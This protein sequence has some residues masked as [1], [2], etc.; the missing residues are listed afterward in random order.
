MIK[1]GTRSVILDLGC[2]LRALRAS[3]FFTFVAV[4]M[5]ALG[6]AFSGIV[7]S[8]VNSVLLRSLPYPDARQLV[9]LQTQE[10]QG[11]VIEDLTASAFFFVRDNSVSL[12]NVTAIYPFEA[13]FNLAASHRTQYVKVLRVSTD[14]F[15]ALRSTPAIGRTFTESED[16]PNGPKLAVLS[17][18]LWK[19]TLGQDRLQT[20][21]VLRINGEEYIAIGVMPPDFRSYPEADLWLPLQ[22]SP[23]TA[24]PGTDYRV[25]ARLRRGAS[26]Q[27]A[28]EELRQ[29]S[30]N[31][32]MN[33]IPKAGRVSLGLQQL[34]DYET[35]NVRER[36]M[37]LLC[38]VLF[39]LLIACANIAMLLL[40]RASA[41][42]H[43]IAVRAALGSSRIR[44]LQVLFFESSILAFFAWLFG[45]ILTKELLPV[46]VSLVPGGL[47]RIAEIHIDWRVVIFTLGISALTALLFGLAPAIQLRGSKLDKMLR[48]TPS[49][50]IGS[51]RQAGTGRL[52]L[53]IQTALT[54]V[55]LSS[56]MLL[57]RHFLAIEKIAP[58]FDPRLVSVAQVSLSSRSY[59]T[60]APTARM[61]ESIISQLQTLPSVSGVAAINGLP[62]EKALNM[63]VHPV[64]AP[65][66]VEGAEY[67]SISPEYFT[68]MRI[69]TVEG[70]SFKQ[71]DGPHSL[72]VAI[73]NETLARKWWPGKYLGHFVLAGQ[74]IGE[75]FTDQPR[76]VVGV[77]SDVHESGLDKPAPPT[78]FVPLQQVPDKLTEYANKNFLTSIVAR[79]NWSEDVSPE[80]RSA[81]T[82]ADQDLSVASFRPLDQVVANSMARERFFTVLT[83]TFGGF[84]L[85]ITAIGLY[86]LL[87]YQIGLRSREIAVRVCLGAKRSHIVVLIVQQ[88]AV[89][90]GAGVAVGMAA[91][92]ILKRLFASM[93]FHLQGLDWASIM[94]AILLLALV[95]LIASL[96][97]S[98]RFASG[99][100]MMGLRN[101]D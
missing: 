57:L 16:R 9:I 10:Q 58:G 94:Q 5:L 68:V 72:P 23:T 40:V 21:G 93:V 100:P 53:V 71:S 52:L 26:A 47:P 54:L 43:E 87:T 97:T 36:L 96:A 91:V 19:Q 15:R 80:V 24:E 88:A 6:I 56:A 84:A 3:P 101:D 90:V 77:V 89:L 13:G 29:L 22:L 55:L 73:V 67:R 25:V 95:A 66:H 82:S 38:A 42:G 86:G 4:S 78:V 17:Y 98:C 31:R 62:L 75:G 48:E 33:V 51:A 63:P 44:L 99:E 74:E 65:Q 50:A 20:R 35:H 64:D 37:F 49:R 61:L 81:I 39:V 59:Q 70:R 8:V 79:I 92:V 69:P 2:A 18:T 45:L 34:Q 12:E 28:R 11:R 76:L 46:A 85:L 83:V 32:F 41:R 27:Q 1:A 14:F 30:A 60:T 7:F